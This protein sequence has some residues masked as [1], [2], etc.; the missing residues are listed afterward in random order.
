MDSHLEELAR[1]LRAGIEG[2]SPDRFA[3][4]PPDK[5]SAGEILEHLY[6]SYTGTTKG[7]EKILA[8]GKPLATPPTFWHR[9][10]MLVV[11]GFDFIPA[12]RQSPPQTRPKGLPFEKVHHEW[13]GKIAE[14][15]AVI[16]KCES[17]FGASA[18][19]LDHPFI[20]PL[21]AGQWRKFHL[22][23]GKHHLKQIAKLRE[24]MPT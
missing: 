2:L 12:G 22:L 8:T 6:L 15:D 19:L 23:H 18:R 5:W 20:G 7:F 4:H 9:V 17:R 21:T 24:G 10:R 1:I 3:W 16:G 11:F 14:M 13:P